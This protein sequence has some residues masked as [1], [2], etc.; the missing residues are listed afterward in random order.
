[1]EQQTPLEQAFLEDHHKMMRGLDAVH[2]ALEDGN[3]PQAVAQ[4]RELDRVAGPHIQFE[5]EV[6]YP[7]VGEARGEKYHAVLIGEHDE[8]RRGVEALL[9]LGDVLGDNAGEPGKPGQEEVGEIR[10]A[11]RTGLEHGAHCGTLLSH[12]TTLDPALQQTALNRLLELRRT[13][14]PWHLLPRENS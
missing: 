1:M 9:Q 8:A 4:A 13:G 6:L 2:H 14:S 12:L 7:Q 11:I 10:D 5:E 3:V